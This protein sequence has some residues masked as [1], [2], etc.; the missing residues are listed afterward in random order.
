M[1]DDPESQPRI[2][3]RRCLSG[4]DDLS[5]DRLLTGNLQEL[6]DM[7][8]L[9]GITTNPTIVELARSQGHGYDEQIAELADAPTRTR[10]C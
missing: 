4:L 10:P 7:K 8:C 9:G 1:T 2:V 6:M 5:R 3:C